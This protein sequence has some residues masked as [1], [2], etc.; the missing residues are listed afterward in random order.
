MIDFDGSF[1]NKP[2]LI[3]RG[4][5]HV[6][7]EIMIRCQVLPNSMMFAL[8]SLL[9]WTCFQLQSP[10]RSCV[11]KQPRSHGICEVQS[12]RRWTEGGGAGVGPGHQGELTR[13]A[14]PVAAN[15]FFDIC[16]DFLKPDSNTPLPLL[17][18]T[19]FQTSRWGLVPE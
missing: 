8:M 12:D 6:S 11:P 16:F 2:C 19:I 9:Q 5:P 10:V 3:P 14:L 4:Y 13:P 18:L 17:N 7:T 15:D 1:S